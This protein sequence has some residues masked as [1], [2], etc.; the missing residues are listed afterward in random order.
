MWINRGQKQRLFSTKLQVRI[1]KW[2]WRLLWSFI[3][4]HQYCNRHSMYHHII[5]VVPRSHPLGGGKMSGEYRMML[6]HGFVGEVVHLHV[7]Y[8]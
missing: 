2:I 1:L 7:V 3:E 6:F 4:T 8:C 5:S